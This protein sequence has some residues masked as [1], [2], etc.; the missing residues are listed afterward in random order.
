M[1]TLFEPGAPTEPGM[2]SLLTPE[3]SGNEW[4][5]VKSCLDSGWLSSVGNFV[6]RF[7]REF[8]AY[9]G[10]KFAVATASGTAALHIALLVAGVRPDDEVLVPTLTFIAPA[11][12]VRYVDAWPV[13]MDVDADYW[14]MDMNKI[15]DF[16]KHECVSDKCMLRNK[17]TGRRISTVLP[18]HILGHPVDMQPLRELCEKY[19]LSIV[20]DASEA[21]AARYRDRYV[22]SIGELGCFSFNGNKIITTGGGGMIVTNDSAKAERARYLTTQA[23]D[24]PFRYVH[25]EIGFNY[26]LT[27]L[28]AAVGCA[29]LECLTKFV[30]RKRSIAAELN[31]GLDD[32]PGLRLPQEAPWAS[33]SFW[34]Y[35]VLLDAALGWN[36]DTVISKLHHDG[37]Q[38]RPLWQPMHLS[39]AHSGCQSYFCS[40]SEALVRSA[41]SLPSSVG[42]GGD[43]IAYISERLSSYADHKTDDP[44]WRVGFLKN[45]FLTEC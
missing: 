7:E 2:I 17:L 23:K 16:L 3:F 22:G 12:A 18:V 25:N 34:L 39:K 40:T 9:V 45:S 21:L 36:L 5:Y 29:Q 26:R 42:L 8:A 11:N 35:T 41:L 20:E 37:I 1:H 6:E 33:S 15:A 19:G 38:S 13:F 27:N 14:Q 10:T 43:Q 4:V 30:E 24:D 32:I 28:Q 31:E 44:K